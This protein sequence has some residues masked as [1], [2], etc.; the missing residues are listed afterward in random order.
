M[1]PCVNDGDTVFV[2][3]TADLQ[4]GDVGIFC[5][6]GAMYC[7]QFYKGPLGDLWLVS[8]NENRRSSNVHVSA[9]SNSTVT[10][11][12]KVILGFRQSLPGYFAGQVDGVPA[13]E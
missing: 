13:E 12:G 10:C 11:F 3:R 7:K 9:E 5:V 1:S 2:Q 4:N 8:L 6:D